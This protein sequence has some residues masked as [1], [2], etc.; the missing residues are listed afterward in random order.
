MTLIQ[1]H[2]DCQRC[3]V[4]AIEPR[5]TKPSQQAALESARLPYSPPLQHLH[6]PLT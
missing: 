5:N 3:V 4:I 2:L 6:Y 1:E